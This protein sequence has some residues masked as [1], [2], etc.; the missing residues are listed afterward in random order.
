MV[1]GFG[2]TAIGYAVIVKVVDV[3]LYPVKVIV[4]LF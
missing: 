3:V 2:L 1:G 4:K